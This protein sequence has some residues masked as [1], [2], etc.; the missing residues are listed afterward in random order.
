VQDKSKLLSIL[1]NSCD[2]FEDC[3]LPFF[4]L[5]S[6][7]WNN[8]KL[9]IFLNTETK[10]FSYKNLG[11]ITT[12]VS[13]NSDRKL[14]WSECLKL[15]LEKINTK[16]ILYLQEDYFLEYPVKEMLIYKL[17][18]IMEDRDIDLLLLTKSDALESKDFIYEVKRKAKFRVSIQPGIWKTSYLKS[19]LRNHEDAWQFESYASRRS[20]K[21]QDKI[22]TVNKNFFGLRKMV[23]PYKKTGITAGKWME[24]IV[25]PL[26]KENKIDINFS[27]RGFYKPTDRNKKRKLLINRIWDRIRSLR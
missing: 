4:I 24:K 22:F 18:K 8:C 21:S 7:N 19:S 5:F 11:I 2:E 10:S 25:V 1:V 14:S 13:I 27:I 6:K 26:F 15:A 9:K 16:Y 12:K 23:Y 20:H 3:W 17:L